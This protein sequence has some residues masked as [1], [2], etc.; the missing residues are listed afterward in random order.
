MEQVNDPELDQRLRHFE[1]ALRANPNHPDPAGALASVVF[2]GFTWRDND[3]R[4]EADRR[5][6]ALLKA[7]GRKC[8]GEACGG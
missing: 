8:I 2:S 1:R 5:I 4:R 3:Q 6:E 7:H